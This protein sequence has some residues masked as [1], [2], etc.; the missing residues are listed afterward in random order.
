M[1]YYSDYAAISR[2]TYQISTQATENIHVARLFGVAMIKIILYRR[3]FGE[4][5]VNFVEICTE[6]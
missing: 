2:Q 1:N 3:H 6:I 4:V 5:C